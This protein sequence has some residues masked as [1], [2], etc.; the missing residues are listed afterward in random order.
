MNYNV[1][2]LNNKRR[3][4]LFIYGDNVKLPCHVPPTQTSS[5]RFLK[6]SEYEI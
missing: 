3:A 6:N 4:G 2:S 1:D 5:Y